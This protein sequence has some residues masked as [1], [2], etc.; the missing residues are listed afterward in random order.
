MNLRV[1]LFSAV[2]VVVTGGLVRAADETAPPSYTKDVKPLVAK[3]CMDCHSGARAK[4]G[5]KIDTFDSFTRGGRMVVAEQPDRSQLVRMMEGKGKK[6]PPPRSPQPKAEEITLIRDW[7]K[8][9]AKDDTDTADDKK[10]VD[11]TDKK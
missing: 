2:V 1:T 4:K 6:M 10:K 11:P 9:G 3:Y 7:I 5:Y 8:A